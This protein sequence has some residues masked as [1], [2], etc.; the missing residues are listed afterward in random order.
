VPL[1]LVG[2]VFLAALLAL[3]PISLVQ[4]YRMV[5]SR[6]RARG[7]LATINIVGLSISAMMF[8]TGAA[9]SNA[10]IPR[11]FTYAVGGLGSGCVL[12]IAGLALTR[13]ERGPDSLHYTPNRWLVL[14]VM[15]LVTGRIFYG[16]FR[17]WHAWQTGVADVNWLGVSSLA[18]SMAAGALVLGYY[19]VYWIGVRRR[20]RQRG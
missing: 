14:A 12:G 10:W 5:T 13:W 16:F 3:I 8:L 6:Q 11:A 7:W 18:G 15:L 1:V 4:R 2:L 9:I 17:A 19:L 20:L